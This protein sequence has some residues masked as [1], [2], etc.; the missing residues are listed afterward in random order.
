[1]HNVLDFP[2]TTP[3]GDHRI[4]AA[5][6]HA[7]AAAPPSIGSIYR[8]IGVLSRTL[9]NVKSLCATMPAGPARRM[10][11]AEHDALV[12]SLHATRIVASRL[13]AS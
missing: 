9:N 7:G 13:L 8:V 6:P 2:R 10:L 4:D 5:R 1:M 11:E 12:A 3:Q